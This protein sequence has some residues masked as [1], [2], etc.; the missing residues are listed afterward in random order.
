MTPLLPLLL[1]LALAVPSKDSTLEE[2]RAEIAKEILPLAGRIKRQIE[3][4]DVAALLARVPAEGLRCGRE[5]VPK[6]RVER[7]LRAKGS[8][9][10]AFFFGG[11]AATAA[12]GQP[13][14]LKELFATAPEVALVVEFRA[15][16]SS[17]T[18][19]PC[20]DYRA[21]DTITPG[22][23]LCFVRRAGQWW[24]TQSLYPC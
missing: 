24:F 2:R 17:D 15:D 6:D 10:H 3:S 18:G 4:G 21:K 13:A 7:D 1:T 20:V 22:A 16:P 11:P 8:W 19:I 23:P 5:L 12:P 9:L 14:S